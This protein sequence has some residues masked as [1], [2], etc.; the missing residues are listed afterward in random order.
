MYASIRRYTG[1]DPR[2]FDQL[3]Q[4]RGSLEAALGRTP[5][6]R[7]WFLV[8]TAEGVTT[9]TLCDDQ[10]GAE[11][12]VRI[13]ASWVRETIP[14]MISSPPQVSNGEVAQQIGG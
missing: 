5:G 1:V 7:S 13:A 10:A 14:G 6:F 8:R 9:V 12:S 2:L 11:E 4:L 3:E